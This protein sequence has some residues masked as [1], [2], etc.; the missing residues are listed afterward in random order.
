MN[1]SRRAIS[2]A[3]VLT[4][5]AFVLTG[6]V[7]YLLVK[8]NT[9]FL[10][11]E[12]DRQWRTEL[13]YGNFTGGH[14][15]FDFPTY[16]LDKE[17]RKLEDWRG[18]KQTGFKL[19]YC[20]SSAAGGL[21]DSG[22]ASGVDYIEDL[23]FNEEE[24]VPFGE[25]RFFINVTVDKDLNVFVNRTERLNR[26]ESKRFH[27]DMVLDHKY[28]NDMGENMSCMVRFLQNTTVTNHGI[29]KLSEVEFGYRDEPYWWPW[30]LGTALQ[31]R[32]RL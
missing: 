23:P 24:Y 32:R 30:D 26:G 22:G 17:E 16:Y 13:V 1:R 6:T 19:A 25:S 10:L 28:Q 11:V 4:V 20:S 2:I 5:M 15:C 12:T 18:P 8:A 7:I 3:V 21:L 9:R 27:F 14:M 31:S 29:W